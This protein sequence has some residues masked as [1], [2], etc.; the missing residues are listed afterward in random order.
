MKKRS[1]AAVES[2]AVVNSKRIFL[3]D[4]DFVEF[5][6]HFE[7]LMRSLPTNHSNEANSLIFI[8]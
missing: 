3:V 1:E 6:V 8:T 2:L 5:K 7:T 4:L